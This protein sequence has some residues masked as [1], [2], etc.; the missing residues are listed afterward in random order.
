M[1]DEPSNASDGASASERTRRR[2]RGELGRDELHDL[3]SEDRRREA[4]A[5]AVGAVAGALAR[6]LDRLD[7]RAGRRRHLDLDCRAPRRARR[8]SRV[9][10]WFIASETAESSIAERPSPVV[11]GV[12]IIAAARSAASAGRR[13]KRVDPSTPGEVRDL[14]CDHAGSRTPRTD[15]SDGPRRSASRPR[16]PRRRAPTARRAAASAA[17]PDARST[18]TRVASAGL[19]G[20][21]VALHRPR[22]RSTTSAAPPEERARGPPASAAGSDCT[23]SAVT[24]SPRN[25]YDTTIVSGSSSRMPAGVVDQAR[26]RGADGQLERVALGERR[27]GA[28]EQGVDGR[29][30]RAR[31]R[32]RPRP[33]ADEAERLV[34]RQI[35]TRLSPTTAP[36]NGIVTT[37]AGKAVVAPERLVRRAD[38][39]VLRCRTSSRAR[40]SSRRAPVSA[41]SWASASGVT[42]PPPARSRRRRRPARRDRPGD[43]CLHL[44]GELPAVAPGE[45]LV[46]LGGPGEQ[47]RAVLGRD[48]EPDHV[49]RPQA[50]HVLDAQLDGAELGAHVDLDLVEAVAQRER[51]VVRALAREVGVRGQARR[52]RLDRAVRHAE[53]HHAGRLVDPHLEAQQHRQLVR[54][55]DLR[56]LRVHLGVAQAEV[57]ADELAPGGRELGEQPGDQRARERELDVRQLAQ[58]VRRGADAAEQAV[59]DGEDERQVERADRVRLERLELEDARQRG[60]RKA[61]D[62]LAV[63]DLLGAE[64]GDVGDAA[65]RARQVRRAEARERVVQH[66]E[67]VQLIL[68]ELRRTSE[69]HVLDPPLAG[70]ARLVGGVLRIRRDRGEQRVD[71]GLGKRVLAAHRDVIAS[72]VA[73]C[74]CPPRGSRCPVRGAATSRERPHRTHDPLRH[75]GLADRATPLSAALARA[76]GLR[77]ARN[78]RQEAI[79]RQPRDGLLG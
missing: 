68:V 71:L 43:R 27:R 36:S 49:A 75:L 57:D 44:H 51:R 16:P 31:D 58:P 5:R 76:P 6:L 70:A 53:R 42:R 46:G 26:G 40:A 47:P 28:L 18:A 11:S 21:P 22:T 79:L 23:I 24:D 59:D 41:S 45:D 48:A 32:A 78:D 74:A 69:V 10:T 63:G 8:P 54:R 72:L 60:H 77:A 50:E 61:R 38:G 1:S 3:G 2:A 73:C 25:R 30:D 15:R 34:G 4:E 67:R 37:T 66:L 13:M 33:P 65:Q 19:G 62:E 12:P 17:T 39:R 7:D 55:R 9:M 29:A 20:S 14:G 56:E 52:D 35:T 64:H